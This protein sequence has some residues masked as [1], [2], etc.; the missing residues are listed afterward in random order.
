MLDSELPTGC[1]PAVA[2]PLVGS[3]LSILCDALTQAEQ[4]EKQR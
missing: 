4:K 1:D 3:L 2:W